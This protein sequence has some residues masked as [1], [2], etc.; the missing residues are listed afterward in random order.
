MAQNSEM[1]RFRFETKPRRNLDATGGHGREAFSI[2]RGRL[3]RSE[4]CM[5]RA[6]MTRTLII[7]GMAATLELVCAGV[8]AG[9]EEFFLKHGGYIEGEW[10]NRNEKPA[11]V[12]EIQPLMG[13]RLTL[14]IEQVD[15]VVAKSPTLEEYE[16][17]LPKVPDTVA[18]QW[19]MAE[20]CRKNGLKTERETHLRAILE[21]DADHAAARRVLGYSKIDGKWMQVDQWRKSHG[22]VRYKGAWRL[23]QEVELEARKERREVEQSQWRARIRRWRS[24]VVRQ[25]KDSEDALQQLQAIDSAMAV[26]ALAEILTD[27]KEPTQ[28]KSVC[29]R[30]LGRFP[31]TTSVESMIRCAISDPD[32]ELRERC[33]DELKRHD[34]DYAVAFLTKMLSDKDNGLVNRAGWVLGRLENPKAIP[35]LIDALTTKHRFRIQ[36]SGGGNYQAGFSPAGGGGF[37]TGGGAKLVEREIQNK[38]VL[39]ALTSLVPDG[40]NY[41]YSEPSWKR[42]YAQRAAAANVDLRRDG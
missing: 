26:P 41:A 36:G 19:K 8:P 21:L 20:Y 30:V 9:A 14:S 37:S 4:A 5:A 10:L 33:I 11:R 23:P 7:I 13:G 38:S 34:T 1:Q 22:Y 40:V 39:A 16:R 3:G 12:Y 18:G 35:A 25:R 2:E 42:W 32:R 6:C 17:L 29:L 27:R 31:T 24:S 28:L 15:R